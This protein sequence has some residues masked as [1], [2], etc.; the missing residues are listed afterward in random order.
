MCLLFDA[1]RPVQLYPAHI[2]NDYMYTLLG[3]Y[4][5]KIG[6]NCAEVVIQSEC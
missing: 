3:R 1:V 6:T 4:G 5:H 2:R